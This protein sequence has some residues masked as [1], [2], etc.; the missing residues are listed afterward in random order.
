[1]SGAVSTVG[2]LVS[3][4]PVSLAEAD[5]LLRRVARQAGN[6]FGLPEWLGAAARV[7]EPDAETSVWPL[8]RG[9]SPPFGALVLARRGDGV[10]RLLGEPLADIAGPVA[11]PGDHADAAAA[12]GAVLD[13]AMESGERFEGR[14]VPVDVAE[15]IPGAAVVE[16]HASPTVNCGVGW[17][18]YLDG[19]AARRRRRLARESERLLS[20]DFEIRDAVTPEDVRSALPQLI[21][22]HRARFGPT[23]T[24]A[25]AR[26]PFFE[27]ALVGLAE[28][29]VVDIRLLEHDGRPVAALLCFRFGGDDWYYQSGWDPAWAGL[30]VGRCLFADSVRRAFLDGRNRFRLLRGDEEYK[31]YWATSDDPVAVVSF[32]PGPGRNP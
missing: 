28:R 4:P 17:D 6:P 8:R 20:A 14:F 22:L 2:E 27:D 26:V 9:D 30:S 16:R 1:V 15:R 7:L 29:E 10:V 18:A 11:A 32:E 24:F 23:R 3:D 31:S 25:E 13:R 21:D 12:M 5:G 19:V